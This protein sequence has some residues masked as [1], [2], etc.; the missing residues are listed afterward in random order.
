MPSKDTW[1]NITWLLFH[2]LATKIDETKFL[3][4]KDTVIQIIFDIC[5]RLPCPYCAEHATQTLQKAYI[6]NIRT[7]AH[8]VEFLRQFHNI[9]NIRVNKKQISREELPAMYDNKNLGNIIRTFYTVYNKSDYNI[10][11]VAY[12]LERSRYL[13][14]LAKQLSI[15]KYAIK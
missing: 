13:N 9:V 6:K 15:I 11:L 12:K 5:G 1:G 4:I 7:K 10:K 3:E 8:F 2:T 14:K